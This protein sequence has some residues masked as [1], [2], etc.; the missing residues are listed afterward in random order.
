MKMN[1]KMKDMFL[2]DDKEIYAE[3]KRRI[4]E[5]RKKRGKKLDF[6]GLSLKEIPPEIAELE[7]LTELDISGSYLKKIPAFIGKI[8]SLKKLS[9]GTNYS[10]VHDY[11]RIN[12]ILPPA[13]GNLHNLRSLTLSHGISEI[14]EWVWGL[15]NLEA[16]SIYNECIETIPAA[17]AGLNKLKKLRISGG[18]ITKLPDEI[19]KH[20]PLE[21]LDL[22]CPELKKLPDSFSNL[23]LMRY[24]RFARSKLTSVPDFICGWVNLISLDIQMEWTFQGPVARLKNIPNNIGNLKNLIN[25]NLSSTYITQIPDSLGDCPLEY[26]ELS[27][28]FS[29]IPDGFG[30]LSKLKILNLSSEKTITLPDSLGNLAALRKMEIRS[31]SVVIPDSFGKLAALEKISLLAGKDIILPKTLGGLSSLI[32]L[33]IDAREIQTIPGSIGKCRNLKLLYITSDK[34]RTLP[35]SICE[36][37]KLEELNLDTFNLKKLPDSF[38]RLAALKSVNIFS[39]ALTSLPESICNLKKLKTLSIDAYNVNKLPDTFK[40]LSYVKNPNVH[41]GSEKPKFPQ[42]KVIKKKRG[43]S[44]DELTRMNYRYRWQILETYSVKELEALLRSAPYHNSASV[45][46]KE[47]FKDIMMVRRNMLNR[48]FKWT[49]ENK[50]RIAK[51]SDEFTK[52]WEDGYS[53]AKTLLETLY[54]KEKNKKSFKDNYAAEIILHPDVV[55]EEEGGLYTNPLFDTIIGYL[56]LEVDLNI[57]VKYDPVTKNENSFRRSIHINRDLSWNIEGFGDIDLEGYYICYALHILY[58]HNEWA[59]EDIPKIN[60]IA[61]EVRVIGDGEVF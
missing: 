19:G 47:V 33:Y 40:K 39:G 54:K 13:L 46:E 20:L 58:S 48:K 16:L 51:V 12:L 10:S 21:A 11:E 36:L 55:R 31:P 27:G 9:V 43:I 52:A 50:K 17:I 49:D 60:R 44:F 29:K 14:P 22:E 6:S 24:F 56:N 38:G 35:Q 23:T 8:K 42:Q 57:Y 7:T 37:K 18:K 41:I 26:L 32:E 30:N 5:C 61:V 34:L 15:K 25:L 28:N 59:F 53:K 45:G 3:A 1:R 4:K 2:F